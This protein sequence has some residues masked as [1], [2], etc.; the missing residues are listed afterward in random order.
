MK[1][2]LF[3]VPLGLAAVMAGVV[4][5]T[6][7]SETTLVSTATGNASD[8]TASAAYPHF[9]GSTTMVDT[10]AYGRCTVAVKT[11][12]AQAYLYYVEYI[13]FN[14]YWTPATPSPIKVNHDQR[15]I[16]SRHSEVNC[17]SIDVNPTQYKGEATVWINGV[18]K[19][20]PV[21]GPVT[22]TCQGTPIAKPHP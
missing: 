20:A 12:K 9:S 18:A 5:A 13:G 14:G 21:Q 7:A 17:T 19:D 6:P 16:T 11:L 2:R 10:K 3:L 15:S 22:L 4:A 1:A 8:C